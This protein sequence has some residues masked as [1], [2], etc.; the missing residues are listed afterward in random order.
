MYEVA[1][2]EDLYSTA[3]WKRRVKKLTLVNAEIIH[4]QHPL[5]NRLRECVHYPPGM[6]LNVNNLSTHCP[7]EN[8]VLWHICQDDSCKVYRKV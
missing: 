3:I 5:R 8:Q 4:L 6:S 2:F 1:S 7:V